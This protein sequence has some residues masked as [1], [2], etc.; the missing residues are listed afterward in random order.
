MRAIYD[1]IQY[2]TD[3]DDVM[4]ACLL[5]TSHGQYVTRDQTVQMSCAIMLLLYITLRVTLFPVIRSL[6]SL[7]NHLLLSIRSVSL[8]DY[9][10]FR[11]AIFCTST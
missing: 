2:P 10:S 5:V 1:L 11:L 3:N 4:I 8:N 9:S 7:G 6:Y